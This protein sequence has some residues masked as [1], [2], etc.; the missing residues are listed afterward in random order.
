MTTAKPT[1]APIPASSRTV[2]VACKVPNGLRLQLQKET[3]VREPRR[4]GSGYE[5][6]IYMTPTGAPIFVNGPAY[7]VGTLPKGFPKMPEI[8]GGY[9][10]TFGIPREFWDTWVEQNKQASY[11]TTN[12]IFACA[13]KEDAAAKG[14]EFEKL[15]SGM[16][17]LSTDVDK[18]GRLTDPRA[19][20]PLNSMLSKIGFEPHPPG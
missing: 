3:K 17:P 4:D 11:V 5:V 8:E 6:A 2:I 7:P 20:K 1:T 19:P 9:A 10:L 18:D 16:E 12:M 14:R 13:S 15:L